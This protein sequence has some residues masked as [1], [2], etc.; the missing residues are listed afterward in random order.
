MIAD[1]LAT[2]ERQTGITRPNPPA[3]DRDERGSSTNQPAEEAE[4][5]NGSGSA[6]SPPNIL[7]LRHEVDEFPMTVTGKIRKIDI[8]ETSTRL[9]TD[10]QADRT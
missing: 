7:R 3:A 1:R 9:F 5:Q 6:T 10:E 2:T 4:S 8:R